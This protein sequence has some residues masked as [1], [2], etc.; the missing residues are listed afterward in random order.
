MTQDIC[1][2]DKFRVLFSIA[3]RGEWVVGG[4]GVS[5]KMQEEKIDISGE[6]RAQKSI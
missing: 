2:I 3:R 6:K 5:S 1:E 4:G